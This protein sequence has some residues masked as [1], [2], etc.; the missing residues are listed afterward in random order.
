MA[1]RSSNNTKEKD[2]PDN[3]ESVRLSQGCCPA[4]A[5]GSLDVFTNAQNW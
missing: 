4:P 1:F 3:E 2:E 5:P